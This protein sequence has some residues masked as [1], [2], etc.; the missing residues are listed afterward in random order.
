[1]RVL[2]N[3]QKSALKTVTLSDGFNF[4][5]TFRESK[6]R[7]KPSTKYLQLLFVPCKYR[8]L[9]FK[10]RFVLKKRREKIKKL[11]KIDR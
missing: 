2:T 8:Q 4:C 1:V 5:G 3:L 7:N 9:Y 10:L 11:K 6:F